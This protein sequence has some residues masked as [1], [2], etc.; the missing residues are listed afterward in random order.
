MPG[1]GPWTQALTAM[2]QPIYELGETV[3]RLLA[4]LVEDW[5]IELPNGLAERSQSS[6]E[7]V[8]RG[9]SRESVVRAA[10]ADQWP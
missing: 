6:H 4:D 3:A 2:A 7:P 1:N 5:I 10:P 9:G 8:A